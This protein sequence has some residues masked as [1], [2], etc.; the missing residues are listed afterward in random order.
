MNY[1]DEWGDSTPPLKM[2]VLSVG[3]G[4]M[5]LFVLANQ[6][7]ILVDCNVTAEQA[8]SILSYL[9]KVVPHKRYDNDTEERQ[10]IDVF[11]NSHRNEDHLRG[12]DVVNNEFPVR[13]IWDSGQTGE[14]TESHEYKYYMELRRRLV[15]KYGESAVIVPSPSHSP[16]LNEAGTSIYCL[17]S[18]VWCDEDS[19]SHEAMLVLKVVHGG[20]SIMLPG[21]SDFLTWKKRIYPEFRDTLHS[22]VLV[23]SH[24]GSRSFFMEVVPDQEYSREDFWTDHLKAINPNLVLISV[25]DGSKHG[26]PDPEAL[27][28]YKDQAPNHVFTTDAC[29][30]LV[31][32]FHRNGRYTVCPSRFKRVQV[33][34]RRIVINA[35]LLDPKGAPAGEL[36][37]AS[38][39]L[40]RYHI[41]FT[42]IPYGGLATDMTKMR[43]E[44]EVSNGGIEDDHKHQEIY[45]K[46]RDEPGP[47]NQFRREVAYL[48]RHLLRCT[49]WCETNPSVKVTEVFVVNGI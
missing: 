22:E 29:G 41:L 5:I 42:A 4:N 32:V 25:D 27:K 7:C 19:D 46:Q 38:E 24:H 44:F 3:S 35:Q 14:G 43:Y 2:H 13:A 39:V 37:S 28:E 33:G 45:F 12:L 48:G 11:A 21:D 30:H 18:S 49:A 40:R 36:Q 23:A 17:N 20:R 34:N 9:R 6:K 31:G 47:P 16:L 10:W 8:D 1:Y 15:E 26:H